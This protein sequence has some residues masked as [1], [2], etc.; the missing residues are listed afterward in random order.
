M[1]STMGNMLRQIVAPLHDLGWKHDPALPVSSCMLMLL[2][3]DVHCCLSSSP[4]PV[5]SILLVHY[6]ATANASRPDTAP[7]L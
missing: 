5:V 6:V 4:S 3:A 2:N 7:L 1:R